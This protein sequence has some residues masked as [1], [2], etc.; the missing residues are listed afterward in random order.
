MNI[1]ELSNSLRIYQERLEQA[2]QYGCPN[3]VAW[4]NGMVDATWNKILKWEKESGQ[5]YHEWLEG[6]S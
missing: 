3:D 5:L 4:C 2:R 1:R 6:T